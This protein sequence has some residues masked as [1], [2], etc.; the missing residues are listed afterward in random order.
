MKN[1][2][3]RFLPVLGIFLFLNLIFIQEGG[4][5]V[6]SRLAT[7]S[8]MVENHSFRINDYV[9]P[10]TSWT[11]DW[12]RTPDGYYSNKGPGPML[13]GLPVFWVVDQF[14][15]RGE[16]KEI[17]NLKR[18][19]ARKIYGLVLSFFFQILPWAVLAYLGV[20]WLKKSKVS[21]AGQSLFL[22]S[23]L[24]GNTAAL[25][26]N[27]Y[28]GHTLAAACVF[29]G[30]LSLLYEKHFFIG[31]FF[32]LAVLTESST[33]LCLIPFTIAIY[34]KSKHFGRDI[35]RC[36][37]GGILPAA[38]WIYYHWVCFGSPFLLPNQFINPI[39]ADTANEPNNLWGIFTAK[40]RP[41]VFLKILFGN[42][43]GI[44]FTQ[45]WI[46]LC[47]VLLPIY[48]REFLAS[49]R[50]AKWILILTAMSFLLLLGLNTQ[51]GGWHGGHSPGP[52]YLSPVLPLFCLVAAL[53]YDLLNKWLK[54]ALWTG[55]GVSVLL[56]GL[57]FKS[58]ILV[59]H[60][61]I[62]TYLFGIYRQ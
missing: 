60:Q 27:T 35:G 29:A 26:A 22:L 54:G 21:E 47:L 12:A 40:F 37:V 53:L 25:F 33:A 15:A 39:F 30:V 41:D 24:F 19:D 10:N 3:R 49:N 5:N 43:R 7:M 38:L 34:L 62:W 17:R 1:L 36:L 55:V 18:F 46:I 16:T 2:D 11:E 13:L 51:F 48:G 8:S 45:P 50:N 57:V 59:P 61:P 23:F 32:G 14:I 9:P 52:R 44:A 28:F 31:L 6:L 56:A 58:G 42:E 4:P 20:A